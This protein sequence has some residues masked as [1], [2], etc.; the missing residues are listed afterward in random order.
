MTISN[1]PMFDS[2]LMICLNLHCL[3]DILYRE[4]LVVPRKTI[5]IDFFEGEIL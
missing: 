3:V 4:F 2:F 5:S 1:L